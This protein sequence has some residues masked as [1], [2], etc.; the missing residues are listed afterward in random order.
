MVLMERLDTMRYVPYTLTTDLGHLK[1]MYPRYD[2]PSDSSKVEVVIE[3]LFTEDYGTL[4]F[5]NDT[6]VFTP[7]SASDQLT[8]SNPA[9]FNI[10]YR[11]KMSELGMDYKV[12]GVTE[13]SFTL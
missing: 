5:S 6:L 11:F 9:R 1:T 8:S 2:I 4:E 10:S 3:S 12:T 7:G 13:A